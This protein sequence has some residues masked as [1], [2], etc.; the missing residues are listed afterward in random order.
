MVWKQA[1]DCC[2][3]TAVIY[4]APDLVKVSQLFSDTDV[5][6]TV[7]IHESALWT[8]QSNAGTAA[9]FR[10][11]NPAQTFNYV[12]DAGAIVAQRT[13][14]LPLLIGDDTWVTQAHIQTLTNKTIVFACNT[15]TGVASTTTC[16]TFTNKTI[17]AD[18]NTIT[19]LAIGAEVT[20]ASTDLTDTA[21]IMLTSTA[22]QVVTAAKDFLTTTLHIRES[23][24]CFD[25]IFASSNI[26]ADRTITL[27][28][29]LANDVPVY[30]CHIATLT[31]KTF[32]APALGTPASG[33][34]T[35]VTGIPVSA[36]ADGTDGE[37]I[38]WDCMGVATTV[39]A[40]TACQ[41]LTSNGACME[42]T[43]QAAASPAHALLSAT[44]CDTTGTTVARG[45]LVVGICAAC[46]ITWDEL[47]IGACGQVLTTDACGD[48][49][50][51][52]AGAADN[53]GNHTATCCLV[54]GTNAVTFGIDVAAPAACVSY[55]TF[56]AAGSLYNAITCDI[57]NFTINAVSQM[58][59]GPCFIDAPTNAFTEAC[60][61]ISPIGTHTQWI[62]AG[63]WGTV[64][65]NGAAFNELELATND[66]MLQTFDFDTTTSEKIQFWWEP[67][68]EWDIGTITFNTKWTAGGGCACQTFILSLAGV[69]FSNS[70]AIDAVI[71][72]TPATT[73]DSLIT[74]ND[75]HI[76]PESTAVTINNATKGEA[77]LLQ[78][79]RTISDTLTVD[80]KL[81]G[82]NITYTTDEATAT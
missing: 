50:W 77:V 23:C 35:N 45:D 30:E 14:T 43:F 31:G 13:L 64:T 52:C 72:G 10:I 65:T 81:I 26:A 66:I 12:I 4:G 7:T 41:V 56:V 11:S 74:I 82:I 68:A 8:F 28:I 2:P 6:D 37:L 9:S 19:N 34:M 69:S 17:D 27:P 61:P 42:P 40:G 33:V 16:Q 47:T 15:L 78:L 63:S 5:C 3:G 76:S 75:M 51:A 73:T 59:I 79:S 57:H 67:P 54:M 22:N 70:D 36:L 44:H 24:G 60:L 71:G 58:T 29:L 46:T 80:A 49:I 55:I 25:Y 38:T 20:G 39:G 48:V 1:T 62:P 32:V 21:V 18:C 53:L